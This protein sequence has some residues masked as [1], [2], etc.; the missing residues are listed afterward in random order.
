M[1]FWA[2]LAI[3]W[4]GMAYTYKA[5][6]GFQ[7]ANLIRTNTLPD[8]TIAQ[9]NIAQP[10]ALGHRTDVVTLAPNI[11]QS[12]EFCLGDEFRGFGARAAVFPLH[13]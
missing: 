1:L 13:H 3:L 8:K 9:L 7:A 5:L 12:I 6:L 10:P 4:S 2:T 11:C